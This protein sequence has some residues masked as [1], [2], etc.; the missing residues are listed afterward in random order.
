MSALWHG[1]ILSARWSQF[2][3][4]LASLGANCRYYIGLVLHGV[5]LEGVSDQLLLSLNT[6]LLVVLVLANNDLWDNG[7]AFAV[8][9]VKASTTLRELEIEDN[10]IECQDNATTLV[11]ALKEYSELSSLKLKKCCIGQS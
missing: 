4:V 1:E 3:G 5:D 9:T 10:R 8:S 2:A 6:A 7:L 11:Q